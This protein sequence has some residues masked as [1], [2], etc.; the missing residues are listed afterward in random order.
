MSLVTTI[1]NIG[2]IA[3]V[4]D[5]PSEQKRPSGG[6]VDDRYSSDSR[7]DPDRFQL[8]AGTVANRFQGTVTGFN[9]GFAHRCDR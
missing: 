3:I 2:K 6:E 4:K 7:F 8:A 9:I 1:R 5:W